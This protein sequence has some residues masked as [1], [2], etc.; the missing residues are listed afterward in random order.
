MHART[1]P[2][3]QIVRIS[4]PALS[5]KRQQQTARRSLR[6]AAIAAEEAPPGSK[7]SNGKPPIRIGINGVYTSSAARFL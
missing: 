5:R 6:V 7:T 4:R 1:S 3:E 2:V